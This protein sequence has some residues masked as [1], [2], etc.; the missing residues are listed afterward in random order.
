MVIYL[1]VTSLSCNFGPYK[2]VMGPPLLRGVLGLFAESQYISKSCGGTGL[3]PHYRAT[4]RPRVLSLGQCL[5]LSNAV[6]M[7]VIT[8]AW[9]V[10]YQRYETGDT[11]ITDFGFS[12]V[13]DVK[14]KPN[15]VELYIKVNA[16][17]GIKHREQ[18]EQAVSYQGQYQDLPLGCIE[19]GE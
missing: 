3:S 8:A 14:S 5:I 17:E 6:R 4:L 19:R 18:V 10:N 1:P 12:K 7:A 9:G 16:I 2:Y 11:I 15:T 13:T